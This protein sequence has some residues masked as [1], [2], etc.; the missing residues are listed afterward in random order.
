VPEEGDAGGPDRG[1]TRRDVAPQVL[2]RTCVGA[3]MLLRRLLGMLAVPD[4]I[5]PGRTEAWTLTCERP[6]GVTV[7]RKLVIGRGESKAL[8]PCSAGTAPAAAPGAAD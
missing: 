3:F 8:D 4:E 7:S 2:F 5:T 1:G 6:D